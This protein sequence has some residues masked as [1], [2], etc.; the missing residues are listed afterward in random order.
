MDMAY[1]PEG[2]CA[3][4]CFATGE[5][6][7]RAY[8]DLL[9]LHMLQ[10][11]EDAWAL[12]RSSVSVSVVGGAHGQCI[13]CIV[14]VGKEGAGHQIVGAKLSWR[15]TSGSLHRTFPSSA[16]RSATSAHAIPRQLHVTAHSH[17]LRTRVPTLHTQPSGPSRYQR[18]KGLRWKERLEIVSPLLSSCEPLLALRRQL[19]GL[20]KDADGMGRCWLQHAK[21]CR[22]T[23]AQRAQQSRCL[24]KPRFCRGHYV[25]MPSV[26][27][28]WR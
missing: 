18:T 28:S 2:W 14:C 4:M 12:H 15:C 24:H 23:G 26:T 8:P 25:G 6:Y 1:L 20:M 13:T 7:S 10:E 9:K 11:L 5:S 16:C 22:A 19:A 3:A 17:S 27:M 21:L